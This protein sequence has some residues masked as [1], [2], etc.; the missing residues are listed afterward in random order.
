MCY[1]CCTGKDS[2]CITHA[3]NAGNKCI[4][5][6]AGCDSIELLSWLGVLI[7][8]LFNSQNVLS[9]ITVNKKMILR[10]LKP[11]WKTFYTQVLWPLQVLYVVVSFVN[12]FSYNQ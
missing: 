4:D 7:S 1:L 9:G 10:A 2:T 12:H 11:F 5:L 8:C 6:T 3:E